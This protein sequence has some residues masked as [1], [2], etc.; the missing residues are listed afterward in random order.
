MWTFRSCTDALFLG[1]LAAVMVGCSS[2]PPVS[3]SLSPSSPQAI[4]QGQTV[5]ITATVAHDPT[6]GGVAWSLTGPGSLS[7]QTGASV[8]YTPPTTSLTDAQQVI[9]SA[10]SSAD[11]SK[12]VAVKI[13]LNPYLKIPSQSLASGSMGAAYSE[14]IQLIGGTPP[15]QWSIYNG[16]GVG[17]TV[18]DGLTLNTSTGAISGTPTGGGTWYFKA[19]VTDA[20]GAST[21]WPLS[22]EIVNGPAGHPVPFLN[23][24]LVPTAVPPGSPG[25]TLNV[26]GVGFVSSATIDFK[27]APLATTFVDN[28]HLTAIIP[29]ADVAAAGTA[30]VTV[31]N[32]PPGGGRSN[33]VYFQVGAPEATINLVYAPDSPQQFFGF[34]GLAVGD[35]NEHGKPDLAIADSP[36]VYVRLSNGDGTFT[37]GSGS[38]LPL[39]IAPFDT[40]T[41]SSGPVVIGDFNNSGH[42]GL[43]VGIL[44]KEAAAILFGKGDGS[45]TYSNTLAYTPVDKVT[46]LTAADFNGDGNLDLVATSN[47]PGISPVVLLGYGHGAFNRVPQN[48]PGPASATADSSTA[49]GDFNGDGKLDL[50]LDGAN[51][52]LGNGDGTFTPAPQLN[53]TGAV[54]VADF[55][56]DGKLDL[57]ICNGPG[58]SVSIFL[59]NG[60][61]SFTQASSSP[62]TV[63]SYP[64]EILAGDF[65][66]DGKM[67]LATANFADGT[68]SLLLGNGDGTFTQAF[69]SPYPIALLNGFHI[70]AADFNG[71]G[72][73]D[74]AVGDMF[75][76]NVTIL[77]QQ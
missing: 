75:E 65:N 27:G 26:S 34:T 15:F 68:I 4:D 21:N 11:Q 1:V 58:G 44:L 32:P 47:I 70:A 12:S 22:V 8:T 62:I 48:F 5:T 3:V 72:K 66:N 29:A 14:T 42:A 63:G 9:V 2:S 61:G 67:D 17:G 39:P 60:D 50:V 76:S 49:V 64:S 41:G 23:Q 45:F 28:E 6:Y 7:A 53:V 71:D 54:T 18:P 30:A 38:P 20:T 46:W 59:G 37:L 73:L 69:S 57:A 55:N 56:G 77:L 74:L 36:A 25:V 52:L 31:V 43:A 51:I 24:T 19:A 33:A 16:G 35:F 13:T 40:N 10:T